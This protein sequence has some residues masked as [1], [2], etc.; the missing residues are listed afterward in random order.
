[1]KYVQEFLSIHDDDLLIMESHYFRRVFLEL[2]SIST[3]QSK[4]CNIEEALLVNEICEK[5]G[6]GASISLKELGI[7]WTI[8][9]LLY[10]Q[11]F[12]PDHPIDPVLVR[13]E[14]LKLEKRDYDRSLAEFQAQCAFESLKFGCVN[15][16]KFKINQMRCLAEQEMKLGE[17]AKSIPYRPSNVDISELHRDLVYIKCE[18]L[19]P[20][21]VSII[22]KLLSSSIQEEIELGIQKESSLLSLLQIYI[23]KL[24]TEYSAYNEIVEPITL[25][26]QQ[27]IYGMRLIRTQCDLGRTNSFGKLLLSALNFQIPFGAHEFLSSVSHSRAVCDQNDNYAVTSIALLER[28]SVLLSHQINVDASAMDMVIDEYFALYDIWNEA[29]LAMIKQQERNDSLYYRKELQNLEEQEEEELNALFPD[30]SN[31][32]NLDDAQNMVH[33]KQNYGFSEKLGVYESF[34]RTISAIHECNY[35]SGQEMLLLSLKLAK[36]S[37]TRLME[38]QKRPV[39]KVDDLVVFPT[40]RFYCEDV[41]SRFQLSAQTANAQDY[42]FYNDCNLAETRKILPVLWN[43]EKELKRALEQWPEHTVLLTLQ[44][45]VN[46][47]LSMPLTSSLMKILVGLEILMVKTDEWESYSSKEFSLKNSLQ[48]ITSLVVT[49]RKL[50]LETWGQLLVVE[51]R[52]CKLSVAEHW[53]KMWKIII[54]TLLSEIRVF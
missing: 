30:H 32:Y 3:E 37:S 35:G 43:F 18:L 42:D 24:K 34:I 41:I 50:E 4:S 19:I 25:A 52:K 45:L 1:M 27:F 47:L 51:D 26:L 23:R 54:S 39:S 49:W 33:T 21:N 46:R 10:L 9:G 13:K 38:L 5:I 6:N 48:G 28:F 16:N 15:E 36:M 17:K 8:Y 53:P 44:G 20:S 29:E 40:L 2:F 12:V 22:Y 11:I 31:F 7:G 14:Q